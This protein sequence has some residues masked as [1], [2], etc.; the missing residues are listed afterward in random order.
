[1]AD[2]E[3]V[4]VQGPVISDAADTEPA[5]AVEL[6]RHDPT[7]SGARIAVVM[8]EHGHT[9]TD[10]TGLRWCDRATAHLDTGVTTLSEEEVRL[11]AAS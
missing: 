6:V 8:R 7:V 9:V 2:L 4:R 1:M 5:A 3:I 10:R 11:V